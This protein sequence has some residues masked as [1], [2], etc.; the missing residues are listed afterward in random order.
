[1]KHV[2]STLFIIKLLKSFIS[3]QLF[4]CST[5][6][7]KSFVL[8]TTPYILHYCYTCIALHLIVKYTNQVLVTNTFLL[9]KVVT[10]LC[11]LLQVVK[12]T[13]IGIAYT[14]SVIQNF[15]IVIFYSSMSYPLT[16]FFSNVTC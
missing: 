15:S 3:I 2:C 5:F 10:I 16:K 11:K 8:C 13:V 7:K 12:T 14:Q 9:Q 6:L 1:M 4:K